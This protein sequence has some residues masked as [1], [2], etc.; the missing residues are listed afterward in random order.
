MQDIY[1]IQKKQ[2]V[3]SILLITVLLLCSGCG[4]RNPFVIKDSYQDY[5]KKSNTESNSDI[6]GMAHDLAVIAP[7]D[8]TGPEYKSDDYADLLIN[9]TTNEV[10]ESFR[11]FER[12]YPASITKVM[13]ALLTL[14]HGNFDD[15]ITLQHNIILSEDGAV[16]STLSKG[17][18]VTVD[19]VFHTMLVK[20]ANDCAVILAEYLAGSEEEL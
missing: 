13:T 4:S 15:V 17:D 8:E 1:M 16:V 14:E 18:T 20:S 10:I 19:E 12:V 3:L 9:D 2:S 7:E 5:Y 6:E 11:C